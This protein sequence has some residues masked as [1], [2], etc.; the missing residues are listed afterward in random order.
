MSGDDGSNA[1]TRRTDTDPS[2]EG[3]DVTGNDTN[4]TGEFVDVPP[5]DALTWRDYGAILVALAQTV[6]L[7]FLLALAFLFLL[8][9]ASVYLL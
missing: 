3:A 9:L 1:E 2:G 8:F 7:P 5:E 6:L 4:A